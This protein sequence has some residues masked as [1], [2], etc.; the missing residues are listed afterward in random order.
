MSVDQLAVK[1]MRKSGMT[2]AQI[3]DEMGVTRARIG[4][5]VG[6]A[7]AS[8]TCVECGTSI[9]HLYPAARYCT[10]RCRDKRSN[11]KQRAR[12]ATPCAN[13]EA[14]SQ[15]HLCHRCKRAEE[16]A[17]RVARIEAIAALWSEDL[18]IAEIGQR[19]GLSESQVHALASQARRDGWDLPRRRSPQ[20]E[21]TRDQSRG[22]FRQALRDGVIRRPVR[23]EGCGEL[24]PVE[25]HHH[26]Y[27]RP[28]YVSWLCPVCHGAQHFEEARAV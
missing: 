26:D 23:C 15:G 4:Q 27:Q 3:A 1:R 13:C 19:L 14:P 10:A 24:G 6:P 20:G 12:L 21:L 22:K 25:G 11:R 8:D 5:I 18:T 17:E 16:K 7:R 2:L 9:L 28:L